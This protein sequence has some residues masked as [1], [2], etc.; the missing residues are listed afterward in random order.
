MVLDS[1]RH[2]R[3][4]H[5]REECTYLEERPA[6]GVEVLR[7]GVANRS[8]GLGSRESSEEGEDSGLGEHVD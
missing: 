3:R 8:V 1:V 7:G 5:A 4:A 6:D 2:C